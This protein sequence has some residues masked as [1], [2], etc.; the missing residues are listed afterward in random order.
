MSP[1][2]T[3]AAADANGDSPSSRRPPA[4]LPIPQAATNSSF[5]NYYP[6]CRPPRDGFLAGAVAVGA[7]SVSWNSSR[8][9][10]SK[11]GNCVAFFFFSMA[12]S[13][14]PASFA[15]SLLQSSSSSYSSSSS[16]KHI[17]LQKVAWIL[18]PP[19]RVSRNLLE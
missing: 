14:T 11:S 15:G 13:S 10:S 5:V 3:A 12:S 8:E 4:V 7:V 18:W 17:S 9:E 16:V 19:G 6:P 1:T 2:A